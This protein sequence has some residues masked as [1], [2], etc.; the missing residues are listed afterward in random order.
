V[1]DAQA[2]MLAEKLFERRSLVRGGVIEENNDRAAQAAQQFAQKR[3]NLLLPDV[4]V[5]KQIVKSQTMPAGT[6]GNS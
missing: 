6:Y 4:V 5:E 2:A 1:L 3:A